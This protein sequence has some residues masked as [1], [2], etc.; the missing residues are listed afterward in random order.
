MLLPSIQSTS[1]PKI[2][3]YTPPWLSRPALG[4]Q[5]FTNFSEHEDSPAKSSSGLGSP[6]RQNTHQPYD[7]PHRLLARRGN[8]IFVVVGNQIRWLDL[9]MLKNDWEEQSDFARSR[10]HPL[11]LQDGEGE[12]SKYRVGEIISAVF[13]LCTYVDRF[14]WLQSISR[15][16]N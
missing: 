6:A 16:V 15:Y 14:W 7:G 13:L 3:S 9:H 1:M 12:I 8:E 2:I 10:N 5:A 11:E 4:S